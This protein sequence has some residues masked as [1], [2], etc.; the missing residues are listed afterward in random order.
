MRAF[1]ISS[2][3][4]VLVIAGCASAPYQAKTSTNDVGYEHRKL[5]EGRFAVRFVGSAD[6]SLAHVRALALR[7]AA[8][9]ARESGY[10]YFEIVGD[11]SREKRRTEE[12][13]T[14]DP[15]LTG[16][17]TRA[18]Y[19]AEY[20]QQNPVLPPGQVPAA[21]QARRIPVS[22][23]VP[24]AWIE[25]VCLATPTRDQATWYRVYR[26]DAVLASAPSS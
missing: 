4:A 15:S 13:L 20:Y 18:E 2:L 24:E 14:L 10:S 8:E 7:R 19:S 5:A 21:P 9:L 16:A 23:F 6:D 26:V 3:G 25:V 1:A 12:R 11:R 22:L 17:G